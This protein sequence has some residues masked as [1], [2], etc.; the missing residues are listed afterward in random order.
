[1][2]VIIIEWELTFS[3]VV[4]KKLNLCENKRKIIYIDAEVT[5]RSQEANG[6]GLNVTKTACPI[7]SA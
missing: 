4:N 1:M 7:S 3:S 5:A 2:T 6:V